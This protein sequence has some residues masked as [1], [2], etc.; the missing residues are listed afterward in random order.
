MGSA[1]VFLAAS[2]ICKGRGNVT[3]LWVPSTW[4][5]KVLAKKGRGREGGE[6]EG[7]GEPEALGMEEREDR[8]HPRQ[9][10]GSWLCWLGGCGA[11]GRC[12]GVVRG[13]PAR[14]GRPER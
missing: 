7:H 10:E 12:R 6:R 2:K 3:H 9:A 14:G 5:N 11:G 1:L 13:S 8:G 4:Q